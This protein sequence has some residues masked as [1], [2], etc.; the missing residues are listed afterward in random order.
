MRSRILSTRISISLILATL[1]CF[2]VHFLGRSSSIYPS[3]VGLGVSRSCYPMASWDYF[4][5]FDHGVEVVVI[6]RQRSL[7][8]SKYIDKHI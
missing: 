1:R 7:F 4:R 6:A 8:I 3:L 2:A 5:N